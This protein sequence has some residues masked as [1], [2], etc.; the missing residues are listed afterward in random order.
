MLP[1]KCID[2]A[3]CD[4]PYGIGA[5]KMAYTRE[6]QTTV[7]QKNGLRLNANKNKKVYTQKDW[8]NSTPDQ[9]YF[10]QLKRVS[11]EQ[12]VF[13]VEYVNWQGMGSGRIKW[14]K[15][16][17]DGLSFK[18]YEMAYCSIINY[19]MEIPLLWSGMNQAKSL[20]EPTIMQG[21]KKLNEKRYHPT[22]KPVL[23]Y[24]K[25]LSLFAQPKMK[26]LD[27]HFGG[28]SLGIAC[29]DFGCDLIASEIDKEYFDIGNKRIH[30]YQK[31]IKL[32]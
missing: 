1:D 14:N 15:C 10:D 5:S 24:K 17:P 7:K 29:L 25:L 28:L 19:E 22:G 23:L 9:L 6:L 30:D 8:D 26:I 2:I 12:I 18:K 11:K 16:V 21:N 32:F 31:Q 20:A 13:G 27:T 3:I 4:I